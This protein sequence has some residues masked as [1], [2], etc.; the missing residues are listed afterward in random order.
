MFGVGTGF[1]ND[2]RQWFWENRERLIAD[3]TIIKYKHFPSGVKD[4][5]RHPVYLGIRDKRDL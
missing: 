2:Q 1:D 5:P 3:G 4:L